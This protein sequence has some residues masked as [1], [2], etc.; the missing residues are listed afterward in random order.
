MTIKLTKEDVGKK[1]LLANGTIAV[2]LAYF[3]PDDD[4]AEEGYLISSRYY[5]SN[6]TLSYSTKQFEVVEILDDDK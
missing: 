1:V 5:C 6:G 4:N 2:I 3:P